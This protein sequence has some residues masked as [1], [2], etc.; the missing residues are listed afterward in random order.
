ML[1]CYIITDPSPACP[2]LPLTDLPHVPPESVSTPLLTCLLRTS[3]MYL[4]T[5]FGMFRILLV[6]RSYLSWWAEDAIDNSGD[7]V[8]GL[9]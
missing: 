2:I 6:P 1:F 9:R 5:T 8:T 4:F 3:M 7:R